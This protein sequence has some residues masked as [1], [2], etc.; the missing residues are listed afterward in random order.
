MKRPKRL[1]AR[2][3]IFEFLGCL[4]ELACVCSVFMWTGNVWAGAAVGWAFSALR[5]IIKNGFEKAEFRITMYQ[6]REGPKKEP[7]EDY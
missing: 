5:Q 3:F 7:W 2:K 6:Q 4:P 1:T